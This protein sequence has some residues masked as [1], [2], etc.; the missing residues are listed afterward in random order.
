MSAKC[1]RAVKPTKAM[2]DY[3]QVKDTLKKELF[4]PVGCF[5]C[6][7]NGYAGRAGVYELLIPND[8]INELVN[9]HANST[10]I[11]KVAVKNGMTTLNES[12]RQYVLDGVTSIDEMSRIS[13]H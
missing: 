5:A 2:L 9:K 13:L 12:A 4:E 11:E 6:R 8:E 10:D 1:K 7:N 3:L